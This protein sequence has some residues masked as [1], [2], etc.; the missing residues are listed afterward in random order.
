LP[1]LEVLEQSA[2]P[3]LVLR[4]RS[5]RQGGID[6]TRLAERAREIVR[7]HD[8]LRLLVVVDRIGFLEAASLRS[9]LSTVA[10]LAG[11]VERVA[12]VGD[13]GWLKGVVRST[14]SGRTELRLFPST[15]LS[16]ARAWIGLAD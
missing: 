1:V 6:P 14:P 4:L 12:I 10:G 9:H 16:E 15:G 8:T 2:G 7:L 5:A 3:V 13:Q 11:D